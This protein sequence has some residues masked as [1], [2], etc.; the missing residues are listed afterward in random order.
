M[1]QR[2][3]LVRQFKE[4]W[5]KK[6]EDD[7]GGGGKEEDKQS[8]KK[9]GEAIQR[10]VAKERHI[11]SELPKVLFWALFLGKRTFLGTFKSARTFLGTF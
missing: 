10:E 1:V 4:K 7:D 3:G 11:D 5:P 8:K 9:V 2:E 6:G